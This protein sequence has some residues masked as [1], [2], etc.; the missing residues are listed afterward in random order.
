[1]N[2]CNKIFEKNITHRP[3]SLAAHYDVYNME[4]FEA[5]LILRWSKFKVY[6]VLWVAFLEEA[7]SVTIAFWGVNK[8]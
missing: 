7:T 2:L 4:Y 3:N 5:E 6:L 1:M 8:E